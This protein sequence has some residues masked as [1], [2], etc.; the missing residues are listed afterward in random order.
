MTPVLSLENQNDMQNMENEK[1]KTRREV[2][3]HLSW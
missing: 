1:K 2:K 3:Q